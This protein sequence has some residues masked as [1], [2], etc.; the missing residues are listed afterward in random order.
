MSSHVVTFMVT[1]PCEIRVDAK[2]DENAVYEAFE[3]LEQFGIEAAMA[4]GAAY[5]R[6]GDFD[7]ALVQELGDGRDEPEYGDA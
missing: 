1:V 3:R 4:C 5:V 2:D 6:P 7:S